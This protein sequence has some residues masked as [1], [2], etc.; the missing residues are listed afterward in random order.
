MENRHTVLLFAGVLLCSFVGA[1]GAL[2]LFDHP[3]SA[4]AGSAAPGEPLPPELR[5][6]ILLPID[7]EDEVQKQY[8]VQGHYGEWI[9]LYRM[10]ATTSTIWM[11]LST[12]EA[13]EVGAPQAAPAAAA[14]P[15]GPQVLPPVSR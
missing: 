12:H 10:G 2:F 4:Q 5:S 3:A 1:G 7:F 6:G 14:P 9:K 15:A 13:W 8:A 11:N